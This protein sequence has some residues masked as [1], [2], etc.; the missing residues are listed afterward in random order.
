MPTLSHKKIEEI[1]PKIEDDKKQK[2]TDICFN[3][4]KHKTQLASIDV[5]GKLLFFNNYQDFLR[6]GMLHKDRM[7]D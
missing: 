7:E 6:F 4:L 1:N 5:A 3:N 2:I